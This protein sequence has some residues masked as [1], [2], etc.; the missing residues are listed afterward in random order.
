MSLAAGTR[1]G[2]YEILAPLGAGGMGEVYRANDFRLKR[3][4]AIKILPDEVARDPGRLARFEREAQLLAALNH[5]NIATI[6]GL[7][8][9]GHT[10]CLV[11][12][13]VEG[14]TLAARMQ[15]S[16]VQAKEALDIARQIAE[17]LEVAH[18]R[19]I[20][21][22]D[23]KP[24]NVM[25]TPDGGVKILYFGLAKALEGAG[26]AVGSPDHSQSPTM[27][28][29]A[30]RAGVILGTAAYMSP[31]QARGRSV[32]K[33]SDIWAFGVILFEMLTGRTMFAGET[34]SDTL[35]G[36][37]RAETDWRTL[38]A[39]LSSAAVRLL[40]R[41]LERD[42]RLRL[43]DIGEARITLADIVAGREL[44][45]PAPMPAVGSTRGV[46][47][48]LAVV[49]AL[50]LAAAAGVA[51]F[52]MRTAPESRVRKFS[53]EI[54]NLGALSGFTI[55]PDGE[56][57]AFVND[58]HLFV[59]RL[60]TLEAREVPGTKGAE[61]PFWSPDSQS[62]GYFAEEKLVKVAV[63][64]GESSVIAKLPHEIGR[65]VGASWRVDGTIALTTGSHAIYTVPARGGDPK[66]LV[67]QPGEGGADDHFHEPAWLPGTDA[68]LYA[69]HHVSAGH[70]DTLAVHTA[71]RS[72]VVFALEGQNLRNPVYS[73]T[74][75]ILFQREPDNAGIW[76]LPFSISRL[77]TEGE[78][79]LVVTKGA[80]PRVSDDG[81]LIHS[82]GDGN[83]M[84]QLVIDNRKGEVVRALGQP[85][86]GI[87]CLALAP[88]GNRIAL[89]AREGDDPDIWVHD[90]TRGTKTRV[91]SDPAWDNMSQWSPD[92]RQLLYATGEELAIRAADGTGDPLN[93]G[94]G[95]APAF[96]PDGEWVVY[97]KVENQTSSDMWRR[98]ASGVGDA[99]SPAQFE[100]NRGR[101]VLFS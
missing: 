55:S 89:T 98:P 45:S 36:V 68:V 83:G 94:E 63:R 21:H 50:V 47:P 4:V 41:C 61:A 6:H 76:A 65:G 16:P 17:G 42:P 20:I 2:P 25:I 52:M 15:A 62:I 44:E 33:R 38:P 18:E 77:E 24:A 29:A 73:T 88:D 49:G 93:L 99:G 10:R 91:T 54:E 86:P 5:P 51:G 66:V 1:I 81:T 95:V 8:E 53:L 67:A 74:G 43:R 46:G 9:S 58:D 11:L 27:T 56:T 92:G 59:R 75:H 96:T 13:L 57:L 31:E 97:S 48:V 23:L 7:E 64:G 72:R 39:G 84:Q 78:P 32:D 85:Q 87:C 37:L 79:F 35:A 90:A 14:Q 69:I 12:E 19:G 34:V 60:D 30:T 3:H 101:G 100:S 28:A 40:R 82:F 22:R 70:V 80:V 71:G 26:P